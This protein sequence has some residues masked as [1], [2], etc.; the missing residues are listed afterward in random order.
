MAI[1]CSTFFFVVYENI[2][3]NFVSIQCL[4]AG[5]QTKIYIHDVLRF[6]G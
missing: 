2:Q 6:V 1:L 5:W 4:Q 3:H